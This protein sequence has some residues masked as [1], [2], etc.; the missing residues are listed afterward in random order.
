MVIEE[1]SFWRLSCSTMFWVILE[2]DP[3]ISRLIDDL[4]SGMIGTSEIIKI[5]KY[6]PIE[7]FGPILFIDRDD[8]TS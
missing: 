4:I 2:V 1:Y 7:I 6:P 5:N 8:F 3:T